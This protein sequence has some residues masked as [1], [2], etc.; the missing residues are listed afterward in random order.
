MAGGA[1]GGWRMIPEPE[2]CKATFIQ[3]EWDTCREVA[4]REAAE[5]A[6]AGL[7]GAGDDGRRRRRRVLGGGRGGDGRVVGV[8]VDD[9]LLGQ[10]VAM[11]RGKRGLRLG[12]LKVNFGEWRRVSVGRRGGL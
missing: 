10:P 12:D 8:L 3:S 6:Q 2:V 9:D 4:N 1:A 7:A 11:N 5:G